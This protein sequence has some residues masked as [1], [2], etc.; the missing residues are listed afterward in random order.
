MTMSKRMLY[1]CRHMKHCRRSGMTLTEVVVASS[2]LLIGIVPILKALTSAQVAR[3]LIEQKTISLQLAQM[4]L[5]EI[6]ARSIY[7]FGT[8][9]AE[10]SDSLQGDYLVTVTDDGDASLKTISVS[11]G[12]DNNGD[13]TLSSEEIKVTLTTLVADR[14]HA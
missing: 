6:R 5:D 10:S 11:V 14:W 4:K 13:G 8:S 7:H 2:L 9:Y 12:Y 3:R 1:Y